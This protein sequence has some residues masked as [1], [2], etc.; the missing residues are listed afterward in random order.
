MERLIEE[1]KLQPGKYLPAK[2]AHVLAQVTWF[3]Q[4]L[5][6]ETQTATLP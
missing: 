4:T 2:L 5:F 3:A 6:I 1:E